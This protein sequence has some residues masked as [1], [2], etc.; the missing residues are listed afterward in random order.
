[1]FR[2]LLAIVLV[3]VSAFA[4][5]SN[6]IAFRRVQHLR[7]GINASE[8]FAQSNDYGTARLKAYTTLEDIDLMKRLGFDLSLIHI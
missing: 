4:Q 7:H 6:S 2:T 5:A 8:W 3:S 1:M